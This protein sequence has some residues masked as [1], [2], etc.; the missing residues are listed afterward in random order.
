M[1]II[2]S[3]CNQQISDKAI[4]YP[5][6]GCPIEKMEYLNYC[7]IGG[8]KYNL[9]DILL[10][11]PKGSGKDADIEYLYCIVGIIRDKT[12]LDPQSSIDLANIIIE[13]QKIPETFNGIIENKQWS[14]NSP[15]CPKCNSTNIQM[16]ARK[17]SLLT[18]FMTNKID[19]VCVNCKYKF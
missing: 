6:C 14:S 1:L 19:R 12:P 10:I 18:G 9:S 13:T 8:K 11:S 2:C 4:T 17:W 5:Y 16:V 7:E 3:E 15:H